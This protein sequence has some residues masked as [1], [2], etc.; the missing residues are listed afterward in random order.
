MRIAGIDAG[1]NG[2]R[3]LIA[4]TRGDGFEPLVTKRYA[5]RLGADVFAGRR[6]GEATLRKAV[7][8]FDDM[9]RRMRRLKVRRCRAVATSAL[10]EAADGPAAIER[11]AKATG[12]ELE[13][14][15]G[16]E[17]NRL[18]RIGVTRALDPEAHPRI[19]A[20]LGGGSL[21]VSLF[22]GEGAPIEDVTL[23]LGTVRLMGELDARG[24]LRP[25]RARALIELTLEELKRALGP[26]RRFRGAT[27]AAAG[28][29]AKALS[30][31]FP[32]ERVARIGGIDLEMLATALPGILEMSVE[33]RRRAFDVARYRAEV[34][35]QA[36]LVFSAVGRFFEIDSMLVPGAGVRE[37]IVHNLIAES[38]DGAATAARV[39]LGARA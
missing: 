16:H 29:N 7:A 11:I 25:K 39:G 27:C 23:P 12:I 17:E 6:I 31:I 14:I 26:R 22:D 32:A 34:M 28:G 30:R 35:A 13:V 36:A 19:I 9:A 4:S 15:D 24:R 5:V 33:A 3:L 38:R 2:I 37:G 21:E 18:M 10:R 20:D 1:S 8:A